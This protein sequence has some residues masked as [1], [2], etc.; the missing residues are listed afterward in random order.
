MQCCSI[1]LSITETGKT[2]RVIVFNEISMLP[3]QAM[4]RTKP[5]RGPVTPL[6]TLEGGRLPL[7]PSWDVRMWVNRPSSIAFSAHEPP[8]WTMCPA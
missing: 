5:A 3:S 2:R 1:S 7:S 8:L 6:F 4:S